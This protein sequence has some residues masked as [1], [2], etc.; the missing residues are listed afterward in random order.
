MTPLYD[1]QCP[2]CGIEQEI[3]MKMNEPNP[4]CKECQV[5]LKKLL[6]KPAPPIFKGGSAAT[7]TM[8]VR[9]KGD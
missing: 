4:F 7:H 3:R 9:P 8:K 2:L 5:E 6:S 1:F